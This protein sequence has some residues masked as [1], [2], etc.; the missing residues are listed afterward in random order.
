MTDELKCHQS[1]CFFFSYLALCMLGTYQKHPFSE[2]FQ[3]L[4]NYA[5][6]QKDSASAKKGK[7]LPCQSQKASQGIFYFK[8]IDDNQT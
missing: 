5:T 2:I 7:L 4:M 1:T 6:L 3:R 8:N